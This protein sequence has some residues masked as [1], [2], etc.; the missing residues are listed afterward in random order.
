MCVIYAAGACLTMWIGERIT[1]YGVSNG[2]SLLIFVGIL[3][4]AGTSIIAQ[5]MTVTSNETAI[6]TLLAFLIVVVVI[7]FCIVY[8]DLAERKIP[9]QYA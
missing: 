9:V 4:T 5:A 7:F 3:S 2:I 1:D 8:V 6:W